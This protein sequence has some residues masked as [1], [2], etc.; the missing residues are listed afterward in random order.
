MKD[1]SKTIVDFSTFDHT[2]EWNVIDDAVMGG[3]SKGHFS[4]N[5]NGYATFEGSVSLANNGGFSWVKT[6][7]PLLNIK[8]FR[9]IVL[10]LKGDGLPYQFTIKTNPSDRHS[11][12]ADFK[13]TK[14]WET[15][16]LPLEDFIPV[17]RGKTLDQPNFSND[18]ICELGI[19]IG[20]GKEQSFHLNIE[21][22]G[23]A[24]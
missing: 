24:N 15:I 18:Y 19:L 3:Q 4:I 16:V 23:L 14:N 9:N 7:F 21:S 10:R 5:K 22:I 13:C 11:F 1:S 12:R 6:R 2:H 17:F 20:N 8:P